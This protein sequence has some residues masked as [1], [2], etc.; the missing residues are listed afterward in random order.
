MKRPCDLTMQI[1]LLLN[2]ALFSFISFASFA[3]T[4]IDIVESTL[5]IN[6][7]SEEVYYCGFNEGDQIIFNFEEINGKEL[8]EVEILELPSSSKYLD[9]KTAKI[10]DKKINVAHTGIYKFRFSNSSMSGRICKYKIQRVPGSDSTRTFNTNVYWKTIYDTTWLT[11]TRQVYVGTDTIYD[12]VSSFS[13]TIWL[14][15]KGNPAC[16]SNAASCT[17]AKIKLNY[18]PDTEELLVYIVADQ[19]TADAF[20]SLSKSIVKIGLKAGTASATAGGS[21]LID[22]F[23]NS[24]TDQAVNNLPQSGNKIDVFFT[25]KANADAWYTSTE[26]TIKT[27][28][29][30]VFINSVTLKQRFINS[31]F[32]QNEMWLCL[33][34][35]N[36]MTGVPVFINIVAVRLVKTYREEQYQ[37][38]QVK[39]YK[40]PYLSN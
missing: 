12:E 2:S 40:V 19:S 36:T 7:N 28:E 29:G 34:N 18:Y 4:P 33:K 11:K 38:P 39:A 1:K 13:N 35:N 16:L 32:P 23:S 10:I 14:Y 15:S 9:Y 25:D 31:Q 8:K 3:Q 21:L 37:E 5:K 22:M 20:N 27:Y 26:N 17:K 30:L 6:G 24:L